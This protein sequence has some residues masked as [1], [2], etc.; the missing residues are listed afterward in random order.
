MC[1]YQ[2]ARILWPARQVV[3]S[4]IFLGTGLMAISPKT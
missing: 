4:G 1:M 2:G 3:G